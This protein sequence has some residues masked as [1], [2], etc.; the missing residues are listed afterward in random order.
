MN[1][2]LTKLRFP[3]PAQFMEVAVV[4]VYVEPLAYSGERMFVGLVLQTSEGE[5]AFPLESL[6]R[7]QCV[8][9]PAYRS[10]TAA[11]DIAL[12]SLLDWIRLRGLE[13]VADWPSP[14]DGIFAG[15]PLRTTAAMSRTLLNG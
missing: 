14:G 4:P 8:Y 9:G 13:A 12:A 15:K 10:L 6:R 5:Q 11:R 7:L 2:L 3:D 1:E